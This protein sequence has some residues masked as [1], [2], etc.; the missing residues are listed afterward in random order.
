MLRDIAVS[1]PGRISSPKIL[2]SSP[3]TSF[4]SFPFSRW[5]LLLSCLILPFRQSYENYAVPVLATSQELTPPSTREIELD[6]KQGHFR[7]ALEK[8]QKLVTLQPKNALAFTYLG[9]ASLHLRMLEQALQ[10]FEKSAVLDPKDTRPLLNLALLHATRNDFDKAI[11]NYQKALALEPGN[12]TALF[13]YGK[14]LIGRNRFAEAAQTLKQAAK[15]DPEDKEVRIIL[16]QALLSSGRRSEARNE[17]RNLL[18]SSRISPELLTSLAAILIRG[19]DLELA[20]GVLKKALLLSPNLVTAHLEA[21]RLHAAMGQSE[22]AIR[23]ARQAVEISPNLLEAHLALA[24]AFMGGKRYLE[25]LDSLSKVEPQFSN[26]AAFHYTAGI[27]QMR[28]NRLQPAIA[29]FERA[30]QR[31]PSYDQ[32][33][34]LLATVSYATGNMDKAESAYKAAIRINDR[35]PMYFAYLARVYDY[36]GPA[37]EDSALQA[38]QQAL[39]LDPTEPEC[40]QRLAKWAIAKDDVA[41]ARTILEKVVREHAEF[42]PAQVLLAQLYGRLGLR[43]QAEGQQ[44]IIRDL[45]AKAQERLNE[46]GA[47]SPDGPRIVRPQ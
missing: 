30:V 45:E 19:Q 34:F 33:H 4:L 25:A 6:L 38:T 42:I 22:R 3:Q 39:A 2:A 32:A 27:A 37:F 13:N 12:R 31:D 41:G 36:R 21:S 1:Q 18:S 28:L 29:A 40:N 15:L 14:L 43:Q 7:L 47:S 44:R 5:T 16:V 9:M 46:S 17:T 24:E 20:N 11:E 23:S 8:A 10:A 26:A 35:N